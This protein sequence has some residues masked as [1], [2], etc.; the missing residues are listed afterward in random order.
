VTHPH[1]PPPPS[2]GDL[3][4][5]RSFLLTLVIILVTVV[6]LVIVVDPLGVFRTGLLPPVLYFDRDQKVALFRERKPPPEVFVLGSSRSKTIPPSCL[7]HLTGRAAFN[8]A[9]FGAGTEDYVAILR[10]LKGRDGGRGMLFFVGAEPE[11][12]RGEGGV[13]PALAGSWALARYAPGTGSRHAR[14]T[15]V[16]ELLGWQSVSAAFRSIGRHFSRQRQMKSDQVLEPDG[17]QRYPA[18]EAAWQAGTFHNAP[19]VTAALPGVLGQ[20]PAFDHLDPVRVGYFRIFLYEARHMG[21]EVVAFIPPMHPEFV[22]AAANTP[23]GART[24]DVIAL[25]R[26]LES[27]GMLRFVDTRDLAR[28][29]ADPAAFVDVEH[30]L[31]PVATQLA[32]VL[33]SGSPGRCA[34]Q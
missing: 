21:A 12:F 18:A 24:E 3:G 7:E 5:L 31:P 15:M 29:E 30:F 10:F 33:V 11:G 28:L 27:S 4:F 6:A 32:S 23:W 2:P 16:G 17:L 14:R 22:R 34:V 1:A 20:Y 19:L 9:V 8:F 25:F 13:R 26:E